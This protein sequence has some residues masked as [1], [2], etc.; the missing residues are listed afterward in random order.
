MPESQLPADVQRFL[1]TSVPSVP[2]LEALLLF[3]AERGRL[4]S[5]TEV[6]RRLYLPD[7]ASA[8]LIESLESAGL[9]E[10]STGDGP[11]FRV[12]QDAELATLLD[13]VAASYAKHLIPMTH[14]I[15]DRT[16]RSA[17]QFAEAFRLRK[18][19]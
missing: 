4:V 3:H 15:H 17:K 9:V 1:L 12:V 5:V 7:S 2:F 14:L 6:G 11:G 19:R 16:Q 13:R 10:R 8:R 18:E